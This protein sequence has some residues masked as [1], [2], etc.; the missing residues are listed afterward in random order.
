MKKNTNYQ[1]NSSRHVFMVAT[2]FCISLLL[3]W[4]VVDL[5]VFNKDFLQSQGDARYLR[6]VSVPAHRGMITDRRGEPLAIS[7]PVESVWANP[8]ELAKARA[9]WPE[10]AKA[11]QIDISVL[12][13][14]LSGHSSREFVYLKRRVAPNV[15]LQVAQLKIPGVNFK[16]EY[17]RYY[18]GGEVTS[19]ILGFTNI[20]DEGQEGVELEYDHILRSKPGS[21]RVIKDRLG[22]I[23]ENVESVSEPQPGQDLVLS[24]DRRIQYLAYR[25]LKAAVKKHNAEAGSAVILDAKTGEILAMVNQPS[26]NPN[27]RQDVNRKNLRNRAI[28]DVF[29]PG[30]TVKPFT[31]MAALESGQYEPDTPI[32]TTPGYFRVGRKT[33]RDHHN[34]GLID[35]ATVIKK[36]SNV[37]ATKIALSMNR[38]HLWKVFS[39]VGF[40]GLSGSHF[41]GESAGS[42]MDFRHWKKIE[43]A[44]LSYG[45]GV[46][47]T[48]LQL[49][50][51]YTIFANSGHLPNVSFLRQLPDQSLAEEEF[52][53]LF[54]Q[55]TITNTVKM[56][57]AVTKT[58]GTGLLARVPG[59][60]VAGKTGTVK[61]LGA[62]GYEDDKYLSIFAGVAPASDPSLVMVVMI[63]E[64]RGEKYYGGLVAAPVFSKVMSGALRML[65]IAPDD[66]VKGN[67]TRVAYLE[68]NDDAR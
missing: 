12:T 17:R 4:R 47:V 65:D 30:S 43:V 45:Y 56:M 31:I 38:E 10:L 27:N 58:G 49:A 50:R 11:L 36:S 3:V 34:Y 32:D 62:N 21:K 5:H 2:F 1:A 54:K 52:L 20:D 59:Y 23:V 33:I 60:R 48:A 53:P 22:R 16:K 41:P 67:K 28:T 14:Q 64:P 39:D 26:Y 25:E 68:K 51:A 24:I 8:K 6:E 40:G 46:S 37:G 44:T 15:A 13:Q 55:N 7:T 9:V 18:P 66:I 61:K 42:L 63:D 19:H 35:V 57:E 29:E